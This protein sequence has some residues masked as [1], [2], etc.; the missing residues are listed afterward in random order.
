VDYFGKKRRYQ[1][2]V[3]GGK[4]RLYF[5]DSAGDNF[6]KKMNQIEL[7]GTISTSRS[8]GDYIKILHNKPEGFKVNPVLVY[9]GPGNDFSEY[10]LSD[11]ASGCARFWGTVPMETLDFTNKLLLVLP[12]PKR[13]LTAD[14]LEKV[15]K[16]KSRNNCRIALFCGS[17]ESVSSQI[18]IQLN[19]K[20]EFIEYTPALTGF[21]DLSGFIMINGAKTLF[22]VPA[23]IKSFI[24]VRSDY[25][26]TATLKDFNG[27]GLSYSDITGIVPRFGT[28]RVGTLTSGWLSS[29]GYYKYSESLFTVSDPRWTSIS[30]P[31][32]SPLYPS[33]YFSSGYTQNKAELITWIGANIPELPMYYLSGNDW[34]PSETAFAYGSYRNYTEIT[35]TRGIWNGF[36]AAY[37]DG[38]KIITIGFYP[39]WLSKANG[40]NQDIGQT[41]KIM[42]FSLWLL[43]GKLDLYPDM[44]NTGNRFTMPLPFSFTAQWDATR[45]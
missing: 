24:G 5:K 25:W 40:F 32:S 38:E 14:E 18:L 16:F 37:A 45:I 6:I 27:F 41:Y 2:D 1:G 3:P 33:T 39:S 26:S 29:Y 7:D 36:I 11:I 35:E 15:L 44:F 9:T 10:T 17:D 42:L 19:S 13:T 34:E 30:W 4:S 31:T 22:W 28:W 43:Y 23:E 12:R 21:K 20:L 8:F